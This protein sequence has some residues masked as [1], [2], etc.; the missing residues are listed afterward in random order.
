MAKAPTTI[1]INSK[2]EKYHPMPYRP[3]P[4]PS[5]PDKGV[6]RFRSIGHHT[7]G[8]DT[9][10]AAKAFVNEDPELVLVGMVEY[11]DGVCSPHSTMEFDSTQY[12]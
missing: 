4:R 11:W 1:L 8:F 3:A 12:H 5:D 9:L 7:E 10:E 6:M 2:T